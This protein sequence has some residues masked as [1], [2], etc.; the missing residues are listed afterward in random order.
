[1]AQEENAQT[2]TSSAAAQVVID[3]FKKII[4]KLELLNNTSQLGA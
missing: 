2:Q 3:I 4:L 1:M